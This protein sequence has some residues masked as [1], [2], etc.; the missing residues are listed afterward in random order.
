[1]KTIRVTKRQ[2]QLH[3]GCPTQVKKYTGLHLQH[4][5]LSCDYYKNGNISTIFSQTLNI[6]FH[7]NPFQSYQALD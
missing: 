6:K 5:L 2:K 3:V 1:M 7:E 4:T